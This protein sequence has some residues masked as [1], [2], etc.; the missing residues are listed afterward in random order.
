MINV[1]DSNISVYIGDS[2]LSVYAGDVQ[3]YPM[4]F[5]TLTG[6][7]LDNLTW[8]TDV[9]YEG[10]TATS[11]NCSYK[12]TGHYDSGK[13]RTLNSKSTITG[14]LVVPSTTAETRE[15]VGT[16]TL[17]A[18]CSGFTATGSVEAYQEAYAIDY[19]TH[20]LT[21]EVNR[22]GK[23]GFRNGDTGTT[24]YYRKNNG[25]WSI[26]TNGSSFNVSI[27]DKI[28][29]KSTGNIKSGSS[30][31]PWSGTTA[32]I[33]IYGNIM[34]LKYGDDFL[35]QSSYS[36]GGWVWQRVFASITG[37][38]SAENVY[39][40]G[41]TIYSNYACE[42][43]FTR[44]TNL[45]K[46]PKTMTYDTDTLGSRCFDYAFYGCTKL[47]TGPELLKTNVTNNAY[48]LMFCDCSK[49]NYVKCLISSPNT[50][51]QYNWMSGVASTGTFVKKTGVTWT[52]GISGIPSG[53]TVI[54]E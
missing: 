41:N 46:A 20:Y 7:T 53:W 33:E 36:I 6:I 23:I 52:S 17:T 10:G 27:G 15:M 22:A 8:V 48:R 34:S 11:A 35:S 13:S 39:F 45:V 9:S 1:G 26:I 28:E 25:S 14:S 12:V 49:L 18:E 5:G 4:N 29:W 47:E 19:S 42:Y 31:G 51:H 30:N 21:F 37:L 44:C 3:I 32:G 2:E 16:L 38:T 43:M 40:P 54:E 50:K 24:V